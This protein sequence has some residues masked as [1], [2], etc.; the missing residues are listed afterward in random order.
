MNDVG[1]LIDLSHANM[2][3]MADTIR[4]SRVP[5]IVS[6]SACSA[7]HEHYRGTTDGN[8]RLLADNGGVFGVCQMRPFLTEKKIDNLHAYFDHIVHAVDV[9]GIEHVAIGSDRDHRVIEMTAEYLAELTS[10]EGSLVVD[11]ELPYFI[12][13]LNGPRRME[14]VWDGLVERGYSEDDVERIM[15][16]NLYRLYAEVIG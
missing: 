16:E 8:L 9:A 12:D 5:V 2:P 15:G 13:E 10:E 7:V 14:V 11:S 1:M 6:H 3:T 4:Y